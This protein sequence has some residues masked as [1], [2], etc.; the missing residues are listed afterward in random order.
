LD[1]PSLPHVAKLLQIISVGSPVF[2]GLLALIELWPRTYLI[3]E[4][5]GGAIEERVGQLAEFFG[6]SDKSEL[7]SDRSTNEG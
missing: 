1:K 7:V 4:P 5:E 3:P 6:E 2:A